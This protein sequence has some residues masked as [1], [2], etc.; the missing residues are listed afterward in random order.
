[1]LEPT[2][3]KDQKGFDHQAPDAPHGLGGG[4]TFGK[5]SICADTFCPLRA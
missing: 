5:G 3:V 4:G 1:V 2:E